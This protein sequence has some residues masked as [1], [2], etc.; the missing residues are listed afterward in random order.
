MR[1]MILEEE[2]NSNQLEQIQDSI[3]ELNT[4][5]YGVLVDGEHITDLEGFDFDDDYRV[6][7]VD[8][9]ERERI[10]ICWD[11]TNYQHRLYDELGYPNTCYMFVQR[12]S[13]NPE[14]II[15]HSFI[16]V[17]V[18][19]ESYWA[20]SARYKDRGVHRVDSY[21]DVVDIIREPYLDYDVYEYNP[22]GLDDYLT[23]NEYF[24]AATQNLIDTSQPDNEYVKII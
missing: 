8:E 20:E 24:D 22:D 18:G 1:L 9:F 16:I 4:Y 23:S 5:E 10:G 12:L 6:I 2:N 17:E 14:D 15:T 7:P 21:K 19:G 11:F 3:E 13:D